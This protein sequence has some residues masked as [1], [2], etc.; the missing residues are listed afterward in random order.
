MA[1]V[2]IGNSKT[3]ESLPP[4]AFSTRDTLL[5]QSARGAQQP[6]TLYLYGFPGNSSL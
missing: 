5:G 1:V 6:M 3:R 4:Q 2:A